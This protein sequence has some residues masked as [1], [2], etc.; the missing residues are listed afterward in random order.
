MLG[1]VAE[2]LEIGDLPIV[3]SSLRATV[4]YA[5]MKRTVKN[6]TLKIG[7]WSPKP[8]SGWNL[9]YRLL[10]LN[11]TAL[12]AQVLL[13]ATSAC[14][15][16]AP[17]FFLK[18]LISY[19]EADPERKNPGWGW[20]YVVGM[21]GTNALSYLRRFHF[22]VPTRTRLTDFNSNRSTL[23]PVDDFPPSPI[24]DPAKLHSFR[25]DAR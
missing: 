25:E 21:F 11:A 8:G 9:G 1:N 22:T 24:Q 3:P 7:S 4:N 18:N 20:V 5:K 14:V 17:P 19:F 10:R 13:A 2:S 23:V 15:Y 6:V 16:Y 12:T